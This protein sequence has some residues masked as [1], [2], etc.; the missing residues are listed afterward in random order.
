MPPYSAKKD[1]WCQA[2]GTAQNHAGTIRWEINQSQFQTTFGETLT[3]HEIMVENSCP[4]LSMSHI[5]IAHPT[6]G[7]P[8]YKQQQVI[9]FVQKSN[10]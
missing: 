9:W 6:L 5:A 4:I 3:F 8:H 2:T 1:H 10:A 7:H